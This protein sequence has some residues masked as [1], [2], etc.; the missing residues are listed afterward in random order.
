M[1]G[2]CT[3]NEPRIA[4]GFEQRPHSSAKLDFVAG[5]VISRRFRVFI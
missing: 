3:E 1:R 5:T 4:A 2:P